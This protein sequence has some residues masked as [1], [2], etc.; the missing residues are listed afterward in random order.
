MKSSSDIPEG[1]T[2]KDCLAYGS[3]VPGLLEIKYH[4]PT[5]RNAANAEC[6][7]LMARLV[8]NAQTDT[9]IK[10]ILIHGGLFYSSGNDISRLASSQGKNMDMLEIQNALSYGCEYAMAQVLKALKNSVKPVV[11]LIR[12]AAIGIGF[13]TIGHFDFIY[14]SPET[15]FSTPFMA[16]CQSPDGGS[17]YTFP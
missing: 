6:Q 9:S 2:V 14:C 8:E 10:V 5:K 1:Y 3:R 7:L 16:S 4:N 15:Q 11:G 17:T 12:G 13:T